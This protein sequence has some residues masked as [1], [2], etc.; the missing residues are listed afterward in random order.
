V[1]CPAAILAALA[2]LGGQ[3]VAAQITDARFLHQPSVADGR[4][5]FVSDGELWTVPLAGG[6]ATPVTND[7]KPKSSPRFSP[8]G[9]RLAYSVQTADGRDVYVTSLVDHNTQRITWHPADDDVEG[10]SPDGQRLLITSTRAHPF[11]AFGNSELF[12]VSASGGTP[13]PY[14]IG[15]AY[16]AAMAPDGQRIAYTPTKDMFHTGQVAKIWITR[17]ADYSHIEVPAAEA[18]DTN[19]VWLGERLYFLSDRAGSFGIYSYDPGGARVS[20]VLVDATRDLDWLAG[21]GNTL[22][23]ADAGYLWRYDLTRATAERIHITLPQGPAQRIRT[24]AAPL[25]Q[26]MA[27][28]PS[29][30]R[31]VIE[32]RGELFLKEGDGKPLNITH[33]SGAAER[34]PVW[35]PNGRLIA[36]VSDEGGEYALH[37]REPALHA[38]ARNLGLSGHGYPLGLSWSPDSGRIA[39]LTPN[40]GVAWVE[41]STGIQRHVPAAAMA[42]SP[43]IWTPDSRGLFFIDR[44]PSSYGQVRYVDTA[45]GASVAVT[46]AMANASDIHLDAGGHTLFIVASLEAGPVISEY[47]VSVALFAPTVRSMMYALPVAAA[48]AQAAGSES[49]A[50]ASLPHLTASPAT[51]GLYLIAG[52]NSQPDFGRAVLAATPAGTVLTVQDTAVEPYFD[53]YSARDRADNAADSSAGGAHWALFRYT[54]AGGGLVP[55]D[56]SNRARIS[57]DPLLLARLLA[58][59]RLQRSVAPSRLLLTLSG[60]PYRIDIGPNGGLHVAP[61]I[62]G[63]LR[64][65][66]DLAA[67]R[68]QMYEETV[69][70]FRDYFYDSQ[71]HGVDWMAQAARYRPW[72]AD[73]RSRADLDFVLAHLTSEIR[74]SHIS[75]ESPRVERGR[76]ER[77]GLLGADLESKDGRVVVGRILRASEWDSVRSPLDGLG[78][79][80]GDTIEAID[81]KRVAADRD[82][83]ASLVGT[84][85]KVVRLTYL[86][87]Q[88]GR[89]RTVSVQ[90]IG[91]ESWLRQRAWVEQE[92]EYVTA[93]S[94]GRIAYLHQP[95]TSEGGLSEFARYFFPQAD[96]QAVI[97]DERFDHGGAD[98]DYQLD[99]LG[100]TRFVWYTRRQMRPLGGPTS[101]IQGPKVMIINSEARSGGDLYPYYFKQR[102][103]GTVIGTR[104]WGGVN[105][106]YRGGEPAQLVDGGSVAVPDLGSYSPSGEPILE[107]RGFTPDEVV[108]IYPDDYA[109]ARDPQIDRA[110]DLLLKRLDAQS[111]DGSAPRSI[112]STDGSD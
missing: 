82:I 64:L 40:L 73:I 57:D 42:G 45:R 72:V 2:A 54:R 38:S 85:G 12:E 101:L 14:P 20:P 78:I 90:P 102:H 53:W 5:A 31:L 96:R 37:V 86:E 21:E 25:V 30:E 97:V 50:A 93:R 17:L 28:D 74:N 33:T 48:V 59:G 80:A 43:L 62:L 60:K 112:S 106:G 87:R 36:Y 56:N 27:L 1:A 70:R 100:R 98:P 68:S 6:V 23:F 81:G 26:S 107:N 18:N 24:D 55:A 79:A 66:V 99:T 108:D 15:K 58:H 67:E 84:A 105:G 88:G 89:T 91:S 39:Y 4:I 8:D 94:H 29:G 35:S 109:A 22:V 46:D 47:D 92:L 9:T 75:I 34:D 52:R 16:R 13:R 65:E 19:P 103:L 7:G 83:Y 49:G 61:M 111:D 76:S 63:P 69:R 10:W 71:L 11:G 51:A 110:V 32:A 95:D 44:A 104:T 3:P 77:V 41:V